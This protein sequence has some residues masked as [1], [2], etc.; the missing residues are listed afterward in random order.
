MFARIVQRHAP[1]VRQL[2][3]AEGVAHADIARVIASGYFTARVVDGSEVLCDGFYGNK[4]NSGFHSARSL[5]A[6]ILR[7]ERPVRAG[8]PEYIVGSIDEIRDHLS[9]ERFET[10]RAR[11][12]LCFRG[13]RGDYFTRRPFPNPVQARDDGQERVIL[14]S[15]WRRF[16]GDWNRRLDP[17]RSPF[18]TIELDDLVYFGIPDWQTLGA[19]NFA[20]HGEHSESDLVNFPDPESREYG[21]RWWLF[22]VA[23]GVNPDP[24]IALQH[25]GYETTGLDVTFDL[26]T[27]CFF[28]VNNLVRQ[29]DGRTRIIPCGPLESPGVVYAFVFRDPPVRET[30]D[31]IRDLES[32]AHIPPTRPGRQKCALRNFDSFQINQAVTDLAAA[33]HVAPSLPTDTIPPADA[34]FPPAASDPFYAAALESKRRYAA[35]GSNPYSWLAEYDLP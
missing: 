32:L 26:P 13:Q 12:R 24:W 23:G 10:W 33:F 35:D 29:P 21:R 4:Q 6:A 3:E 27:A 19:R 14:P 34:I 11:G 25:Y 30:A 1:R 9:E 16:R 28:A 7:N 5:A 17:P 22:K 31:L 2:L 8:A 15:Y 20:L 18:E